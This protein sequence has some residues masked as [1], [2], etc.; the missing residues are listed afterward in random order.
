MVRAAVTSALAL[1]SVAA[2]GG[3]QARVEP[4]AARITG[5]HAA[6]VERAEE[7][8]SWSSR[9]RLCWS[10]VAAA[11]GYAVTVVTSEGTGRTARGVDASCWSLTVATGVPRRRELARQVALVATSLSVRVSAILSDGRTGPPSPAVPVGTAHP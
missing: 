9:W 5:L 11:R 4:A 8:G 1:V 3:E 2:C 10:P 7:G 6:V